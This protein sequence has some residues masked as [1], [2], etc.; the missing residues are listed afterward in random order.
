LPPAISSAADDRDSS[1]FVI[2][3]DRY[4]PSSPATMTPPPNAIASRS[5]SV[6][7]RLR[8]CEVGFATTSAPKS[9][10]PIFSGWATARNLRL[11]HRTSSVDNFPASRSATETVLLGNCGSLPTNSVTPGTIGT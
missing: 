6:T 7:Q 11:F 10:S 2:R 5:T 3:L 4:R 9:W 8:S 1:G